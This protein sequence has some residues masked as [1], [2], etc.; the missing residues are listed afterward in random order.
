MVIDP[1]PYQ[2]IDPKDFKVKLMWLILA[3]FI[4]M[5]SIPL[6]I[7]G[8][9]EK[10]IEGLS[11]TTFRAI[12]ILTG[13]CLLVI[14]KLIMHKKTGITKIKEQPVHRFPIIHLK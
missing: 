2:K 8:I 7:Y 9:F 12:F 14:A 1:R 5:S 11:E 3:I 13:I 10:P 6:I 4:L